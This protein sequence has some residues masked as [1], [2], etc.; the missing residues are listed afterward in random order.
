MDSHIEVAAPAEGLLVV[1][2]IEVRYSDAILALRGVSLTVRQ[3]EIVVLLGPNGAGKTT[4][5]KAVSN[6]L[7]AERGQLTKGRITL[8]GQSTAGIAPGDLVGRGMVQVLEGRH[9]FAHLTVE[10]N[11]VTGALLH[12]PGRAA[13][14]SELDR[15]YSYFPGLKAKRRIR[16]GY[17]SGGEQQM[18]AVGRA[19]MSRPRLM[20][21]DEPSMGLA[22]R[23]VED[24]YSV[25]EQ[26]NRDE[27]ISF[28]IAEQNTATALRHAHQAC[29]VE[30]GRVV[31]HGHARDLLGREE[32]R[33][34]YFGKGAQSEGPSQRWG[35]RAAVS[36]MD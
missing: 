9:C 10:E 26:L 16:A 14:S 12:H 33:D 32:V 36:W 34:L 3:G 7:A 17:V 23:V 30:T 11:L 28:L 6:L 5:L 1:T 27:G 19:L 2:G 15:V 22:P 13:L 31:L 24:I 21:L 35:R 18:T 4:T 25:V 20:L 29:V 8:D